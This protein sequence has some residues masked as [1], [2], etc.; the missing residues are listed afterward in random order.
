MYKNENVEMNTNKKLLN[1]SEL[2]NL[3]SGLLDSGINLSSAL[4]KDWLLKPL[5]NGILE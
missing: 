4:D 5:T 3:I 1:K 2:D